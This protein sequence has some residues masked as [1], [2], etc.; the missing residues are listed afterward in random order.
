MQ[1]QNPV[2]LM[3]IQTFKSYQ[4]VRNNPYQNRSNYSQQSNYS[5]HS[6]YSQQ[7]VIRPYEKRDQDFQYRVRNN[8]TKKK[9]FS[10]N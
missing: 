3:S 10:F 1:T 5:Q 7:R 8:N 2:P 4:S 6:N 9:L